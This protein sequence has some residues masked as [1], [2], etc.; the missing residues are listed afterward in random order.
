MDDRAHGAA[1]GAAAAA[2]W[3]AF[4]PLLR[5][6]F[7]TPYSDAAVVSAFV[8]RGRLRPVV[9]L[10]IHSAN[11]AAFGYAF[12]RLGGRGVA[13]GVAAAVV[14]NALLW[15]LTAVVERI[16]PEVR[17]GR[18]PRLFRNPQVFAQATAG[19]VLF[20]FLLGALGPRRRPGPGA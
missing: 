13:Q 8:P 12:A 7:G 4:D 3:L 14:E 6:V 11:G 20:G 18:W 2:L 9:G 19:H 10:G 17:A 16:H 5:R 1:A 15:P